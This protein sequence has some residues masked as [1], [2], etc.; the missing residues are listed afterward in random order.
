MSDAGD[1]GSP[2]LNRA[3]AGRILASDPLANSQEV[4]I[5]TMP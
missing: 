5:A 1:Q 3:A 4:T 2:N